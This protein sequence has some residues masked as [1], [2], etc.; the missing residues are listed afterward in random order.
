MGKMKL[1]DLLPKK[2][3]GPREAD[4]IRQ[5]YQQQAFNLGQAQ[6]QAQLFENEAN[7]LF[8]VLRALNQEAAERQKLDVAVP[9][10]K[11]E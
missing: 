2:K 9:K 7:R 3:S 10:E 11:E 4:V 1:R 6:Y 5:E 8:G